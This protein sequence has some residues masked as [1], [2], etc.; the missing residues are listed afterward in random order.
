ME[1]YRMTDSEEFAWAT[2]CIENCKAAVKNME[3]KMKLEIGKQYKA[4]GGWRAMVV[5]RHNGDLGDFIV[6]HS[7]V[8][9][10]YPHGKTG[11]REVC[12]IYSLISEWQEPRSGEV[13]VNVYGTGSGYA[14][15]TKDEADRSALD[16]RIACI[17]VKWTEGEGL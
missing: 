10:T 14:Y 11:E 15:R 4:S 9:R 16:E 7:N 3:D 6:W 17:N 5:G 13:W 12:P 2:R 8:D 1:K